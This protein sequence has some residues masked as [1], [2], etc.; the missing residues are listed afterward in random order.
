MPR[1]VWKT[2]GLAVS[3]TIAVA[4]MFG[5]AA[6]AR[7]LGPRDPACDARVVAACATNWQ[8][9]GY[10]NQATCESG[11]PCIECPPNYGYMCGGPWIYQATEKKAVK[12]W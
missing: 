7:G 6:S 11:Q 1:K 8:S 4:S 3:L 9:L 5:A 12:P 2:T 10:P